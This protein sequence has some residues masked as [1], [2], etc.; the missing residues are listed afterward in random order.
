M[1]MEVVQLKWNFTHRMSISEIKYL[2]LNLIL[3]FRTQVQVALLGPAGL[4]VSTINDLNFHL[5]SELKSPFKVRNCR[6]LA[7]LG[8]FWLKNP[9]DITCDT[10]NN[11]DA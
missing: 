10:L 3:D 6:I 7:P 9:R 5:I 8:V 1:K 4:Q 11:N 2:E